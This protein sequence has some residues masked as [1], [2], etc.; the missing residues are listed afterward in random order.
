MANT[1][2]KVS[3]WLA[4][5]AADHLTNRLKL[6]DYYNWDHSKEFNR[7]FPTGDSIRVPYPD[8]GRIRNGLQYDPE[9]LEAR[10]GTVTFDDPFGVDFEL[11]SVESALSSPRGRDRFEELIIAP[12]MAQLAQEIDSRLFLYAYQNAASVTGALGTNPTSYDAI[13]GAARQMMVERGGIQAGYENGIIVPPAVMRAVR[14][15]N[16]AL[17]NPAAA[18]SKQH[19]TGMVEYADGFDW[20][21]SMS[22][23][24]HTAGTWA[25]AVTVTSTQTTDGIT[26]MAVTCTTGDT[27]KKGDKIGIAA[28]YPVNR[29]T[30]RRFGSDTMVVTVTAD[31][32]G[33]SSSATLSFSPALYGP[34]SKHQ[35]VDALPAASAALTLWPGTTSPSA[36]VGAVGV[37]LNKLAFAAV[38]KALELPKSTEMASQKREPTSGINIRFIRDWDSRASKFINRFDCWLG[39]GT[40]YNAEAAV[41]IACA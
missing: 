18:I 26:S 38:S 16:I 25:G 29:M 33:A 14:T 19:R 32:T 13:S 2:N 41:A 5:T 27:F 37:A 1:F 9:S 28:V 10:Y 36:K 20:H 40:F 39:Y 3:D 30:K 15:A 7:D 11:D 21:E 34:N 17:H 6:S 4:L 12:K 24:R 8:P 35:N 23:Y 22:W 31:A